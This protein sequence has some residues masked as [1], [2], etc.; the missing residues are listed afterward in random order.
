[1]RTNFTTDDVKRLV[2]FIYNGNLAQHRAT[3]GTPDEIPYVN[4][5]SENIVLY[6]EQGISLGEKDLA[7]YL[8]IKF[9]AWKNRLE[10]KKP[11]D[12]GFEAWVQSLNLSINQALAIVEVLD[13]KAVASQDIDGAQITGRVTIVIQANKVANLDYYAGKIH[14]KYLGAPQDIVNSYG[15][16]LKAYLNMGIIL[17]DQEPVTMQLG[18]CVVVSF[19]FTINYLSDAFSYADTEFLFC[20]GID[21]DETET[22]ITY[23]K[24]PLTKAS[25]NTAM[26]FSAQPF[27]N[28]PDITG[29]INT[30]CS[31]TWTL[32]FFDFKQPLIEELDKIFWESGA[33]KYSID[34]GASWE[35]N[36]ISDL[37]EPFYAKVKV[38]YLDGSEMIYKYSFVI[39]DMK[40]EIVN[41]DFTVCT[42]TL[43]GRAKDMT[44]EQEV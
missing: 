7:E 39:T 23:E 38:K 36:F 11:N 44:D 31:N 22:T 34:N 3:K 26:T 2:E 18:E 32:A 33:I 14:N 8:N 5:N 1:M 28:R 25:L 17:Y 21:P 29:V 42:L 10:E 37:N 6:D 27:G 40:K 24:L 20:V 4:E 30:A 12:E 15:D 35:K 16:K 43:R 19:N 13:N 41:G 9:Y